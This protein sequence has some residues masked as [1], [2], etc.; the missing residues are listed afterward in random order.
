MAAAV[1]LYRFDSRGG[2]AR[3]QR[4]NERPFLIGQVARIAKPD[5]LG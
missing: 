2:N 5:A 4:L 1:D 3:D